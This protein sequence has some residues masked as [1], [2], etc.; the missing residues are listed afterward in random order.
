MTRTI[1]V[2][3]RRYVVS[4][5]L[6]L[7]DARFERSHLPTE[8]AHEPLKEIACEGGPADDVLLMDRNGIM[9]YVPAWACQEAS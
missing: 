6:A 8:S 4:P 5:A 7:A 9:H 2:T 1:P 3:G